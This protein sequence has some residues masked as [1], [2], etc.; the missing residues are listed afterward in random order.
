ML[1]RGSNLSHNSIFK[2]HQ[3]SKHPKISLKAS[4]QG[5]KKPQC[6]FHTTFGI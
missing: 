1:L 3:V 6:R 2:E 4:H 5:D